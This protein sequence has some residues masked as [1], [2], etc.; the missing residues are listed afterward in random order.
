M[1]ASH[2]LAA[3]TAVALACSP[4]PQAPPEPGPDA[5]APPQHADAP[6]AEAPAHEA[7]VTSNA[8]LPDRDPKLAHRLVTQEGALL[9]DV[10]TPAEFAE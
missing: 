8:P 6:Q 7:T 4:R 2:V 1:H 9:L 3:L 5:P 10:R